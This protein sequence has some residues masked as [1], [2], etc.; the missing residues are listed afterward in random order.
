VE[1]D[2]VATS[3]VKDPFSLTVREAGIHSI[4]ENEKNQ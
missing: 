3:F 2:G 1:F 4:E